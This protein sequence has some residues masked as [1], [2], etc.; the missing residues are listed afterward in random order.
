MDK[1]PSPP[2]PETKSNPL[3]TASPRSRV[4]MLE[5]IG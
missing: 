5:F 1:D 2:Q 3:A 4:E